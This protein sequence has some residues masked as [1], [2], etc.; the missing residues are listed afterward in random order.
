MK[1]NKYLVLVLTFF[2]VFSFFLRQVRASAATID[3]QNPTYDA[4][5]YIYGETEGMV[6]TPEE[7]IGQVSSGAAQFSIQ[8]ISMAFQLFGMVVL[9]ILLIVMVEE[10]VKSF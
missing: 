4:S 6:P 9:F 7:T 5:E 8:L 2:L 1:V 10:L 3:D